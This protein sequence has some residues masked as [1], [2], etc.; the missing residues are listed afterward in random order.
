MASGSGPT[1]SASHQHPS[2]LSAR[3]ANSRPQLSQCSV[4]MG[5]DRTLRRGW[6]DPAPMGLIQAQVAVVGHTEW[7]DFVV[8]DRLPRQGEILHARDSW[9][10][11]AGGGAVAVV[12]MV[13]LT[14]RALFF[15]A[16]ARDDLGRRTAEQL[17]PLAVTVHAGAR[18]GTQRRG[19]TY[20]DADGERTIT[21]IGDRL[22]PHGDDRLPWEALDAVDGVY[23]TGGDAGALRA[24]RRARIVVAT[25]RAGRALCEA[26]VEVDV[27]VHSGSDAGEALEST[28]IDPPPRAVVT[29]MGAKG[30]RWEGAAGSGR[31]NAEPLPCPRRVDAYGAGD[32]F[33]AGLTTGLAAGMPIEHAVA[34]GSRSG[35]AN[36]CGRGPYAG[37]L[38]LR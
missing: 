19:F 33:A 5:S 3:H 2:G 16:L 4:A 30:G 7:I 32:S 6:H 17:E 29:T 12:Q 23:F 26:G 18:D 28:E 1:T 22:V 20:L 38:D 36:M 34:L 24:A 31:W 9:A 14:G 13:K 37:Q 21:V 10:E 8:V 25:P 35:A 15:T 11:A 27:L